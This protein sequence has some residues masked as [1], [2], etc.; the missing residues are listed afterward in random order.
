MPL[1][2][3]AVGG[4]FGAA[5]FNSVDDAIIDPLFTPEPEPVVSTKTVLLVGL[6]AGAYFLAKKNKL[7]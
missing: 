2:L 7:L 4:L 5:A 3:L 1:I 6:A